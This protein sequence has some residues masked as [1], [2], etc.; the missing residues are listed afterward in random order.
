MSSMLVEASLLAL[1]MLLMPDENRILD[2]ERTRQL[3]LLSHTLSNTYYSTLYSWE[4]DVAKLITGRF[5]TCEV[6][7]G[8]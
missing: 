3:K 1:L 7:L 4:A 5:S 2:G 8:I 6:H